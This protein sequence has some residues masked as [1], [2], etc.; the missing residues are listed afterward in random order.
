MG[1]ENQRWIHG[2]RLGTNGAVTWPPER[3][4]GFYKR[5]GISR[6]GERLS[7]SRGL[8]FIMLDGY[9]LLFLALFLSFFCLFFRGF[10]QANAGTLP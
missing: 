1:R 8:S 2:I 5:Q 4:F 9:V 6:L 7:V 10:P 3:N